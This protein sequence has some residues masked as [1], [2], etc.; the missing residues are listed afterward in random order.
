M[1]LYYFSLIFMQKSTSMS[2]QLLLF[3]MFIIIKLKWEN[4]NNIS[5]N[6]DRILRYVFLKIKLC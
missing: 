6:E 2:N 1:Y 3:G 5:N 4:T